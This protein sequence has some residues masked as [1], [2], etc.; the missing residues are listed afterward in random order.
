MCL[1]ASRPQR[2]SLPL[3]LMKRLFVSFGLLLT[4]LYLKTKQ[5]DYLLELLNEKEIWYNGG[6]QSVHLT[7]SGAPG[8][9]VGKSRR[10]FVHDVDLQVSRR[11]L[12]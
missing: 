4:T 8:S 3:C 10:F 6:K 9:L 1:E 2:F 11:L 5:G 7:L 12:V